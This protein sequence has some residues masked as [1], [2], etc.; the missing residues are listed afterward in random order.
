MSHINN[1]HK[2]YINALKN[3]GVEVKTLANGEDADFNID[4]SKRYLSIRNFFNIFK[5]RKII[6]KNNFEVIYLH[7]TL[8]AF[9]VRIA[10]KG[11]K[12]RPYVINTVHGYLFNNDKGLKNKVLLFCEQL[13]KKQTD[14]IV[15]MNEVDFEIAKKY[16]LCKAKIIKIDG[17]GFDDS[18]E[19]KANEEKVQKIKEQLKILPSDIVLTFIGELSG[20][21]NQIFLLKGLQKLLESDKN[22]KL[23]LLGSGKKE[24]EYKEFVKKQKLTENVLFVGQVKNIYD[25]LSFTNIYV[26]ASKIEGLPFNVLEAENAN[27]PIV[28][29]KIKGHTD[30]LNGVEGVVLFDLDNLCEFVNGVN[31]LELKQNKVDYFNL[32][33]YS[34]DSV[35]NNNLHIYKEKL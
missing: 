23:M 2:P 6:K 18:V 8:C 16:S 30:L 28:A 21:K 22:Y 34:L 12:N 26:S 15:V 31:K 4:F 24:K 11:L 7:T 3:E 27:L 29:S 17:M 19:K 35:L 25:Y 20:R 5:I 32:K 9:F 1:F 14:E 10:L 33:K 13:V